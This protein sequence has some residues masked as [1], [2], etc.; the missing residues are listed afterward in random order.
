MQEFLKRIKTF[1]CKNKMVKN[2]VN[3]QNKTPHGNSAEDL[4]WKRVARREY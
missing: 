2:P 3:F 1:T 4:T